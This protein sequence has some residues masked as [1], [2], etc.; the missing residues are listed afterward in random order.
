[1]IWFLFILLIAWSALGTVCFALVSSESTLNLWRYAA[2]VILAGPCIWM[3]HIVVAIFLA[4]M[5][6]LVYVAGHTKA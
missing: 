3:Y 1:M 5:F 4:F 2:L 6:L